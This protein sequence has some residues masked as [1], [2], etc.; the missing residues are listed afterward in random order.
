MASQHV[1]WIFVVV[2][3]MLTIQ[4]I[5]SAPLAPHP[6]GVE[7][8]GSIAPFCLQL[9]RISHACNRYSALPLHTSRHT[10]LPP[11]TSLETKRNY[12]IDA[13]VKQTDCIHQV[14]AFGFPTNAGGVLIR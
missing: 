2:I 13:S 5:A 14:V 9:L 6:T 10:P 4:A 3:I 1:V 8:R 7:E 12:L 11:Q